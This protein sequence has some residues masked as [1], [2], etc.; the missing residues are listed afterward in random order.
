M[1]G[2]KEKEPEKVPLKLV[3][4]IDYR[5]LF[6]IFGLAVIF[7]IFILV[8]QGVKEA[9]T[10]IAAVSFAFPLSGCIAAFVVAKRY[11]KSEVFGK[12]YFALGLGMLMNFLGEV[13]YY[14]LESTDQVTYPSISDVFYLA[15]YPF[16]FYHLA[17][18]I[19]FFNP[20]VKFGIKALVVIIPVALISAY[21]VFSYEKI[22][23]INS[24]F[25]YGLSYVVGSSILLSAS[26][27][28]ALI[29]R[30]G[31]LGTAWLALVIGIS[32][33]TIGDNWYAYLET[34]FEY[35]TLHPVNLLWYTGYMVI[36]YALVKHR[37]II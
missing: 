30:Q 5:L 28:G 14:I 6:V 13:S 10:T 3:N 12:A 36:A 37:E 19:R 24:D 18:N 20:K 32:L 17:K 26:V 31:V 4:P 8:T 21:S 15:Y 9:D 33:L 25:F 35:D 7:Q 16:A 27:F 22:G 29:F 2:K 1:F 34:F 23:E 11:R